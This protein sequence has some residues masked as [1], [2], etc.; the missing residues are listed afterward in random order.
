VWYNDLQVRDRQATLEAG[1][2]SV[3][4]K[5]TSRGRLVRVGRSRCMFSSSM[6]VDD[7]LRV[8]VGAFS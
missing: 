7:I 5:S 8:V 2:W 3:M 6:G 4:S 1:R